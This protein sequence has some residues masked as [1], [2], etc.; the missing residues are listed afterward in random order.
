M[1]EYLLICVVAAAITF[2]ATPAI[3]WAAVRFGAVTPV[4]GRDVH[5]I[6]VPRLGGVAMLVGFLAAAA[7]A[8]QLPYLSG[9]YDEGEL[10]GVL[11]GAVLITALGAVDDF[12]EIDAITKFAGQMIATNVFNNVIETDID[13]YLVEY[14]P[15]LKQN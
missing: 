5:S 4:R 1:R 14:L 12:I 8:S 7:V 2:L 15:S 11:I 13:E 9:L 6:P 10:F 3:R